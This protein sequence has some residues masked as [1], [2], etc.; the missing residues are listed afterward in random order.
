VNDYQ[1]TNPG[2]NSK[3]FRTTKNGNPQLT[4]I[5][6][7]SDSLNQNIRQANHFYA[8]S[9]NTIPRYVEKARL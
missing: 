1:S 5:N 3:Q 9:R 7:C 2:A 6:G 8:E 4:G